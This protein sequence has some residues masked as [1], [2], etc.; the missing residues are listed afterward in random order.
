MPTSEF[1]YYIDEMKAVSKE[2]EME[3]GG[4]GDEEATRRGWECWERAEASVMV[5]MI[6][7]ARGRT[8]EIVGVVVEKNNDD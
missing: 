5:M 8:G 3:K 7:R 4:R 6:N 1:C 2:I